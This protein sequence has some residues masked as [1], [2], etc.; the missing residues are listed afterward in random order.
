[1][2]DQ[3]ENLKSML[4]SGKITPEQYQEL[5]EK[6]FQSNTAPI[7]KKKLS[8]QVWVSS[9]L[10]FIFV[11]VGIIYLGR[12]DLTLGVS[13]FFSVLTLWHYYPVNAGRLF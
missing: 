12:E 9:I 7:K 1:M 5:W 3:K 2:V 8:W 4:N 11:I 13:S 6:E 10:L